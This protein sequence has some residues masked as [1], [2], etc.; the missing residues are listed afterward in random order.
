M[1][2]PPRERPRP[3]RPMT[4]HAVEDLRR[5]IPHL[6]LEVMSCRQQRRA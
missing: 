1:T 5:L 2:E 3:P 4:R 6:P